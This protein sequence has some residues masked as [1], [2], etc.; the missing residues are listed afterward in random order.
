LLCGLEIDHKL[1][2]RGLLNRQAGW[3]G[4]FEDLVYKDGQT[5]VFIDKSAP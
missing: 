1:E 3:L 4:A 2:L 5:A